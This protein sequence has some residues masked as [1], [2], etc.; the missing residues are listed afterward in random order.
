MK[1]KI[2]GIHLKDRS[3]EARIV[4]EILS[5]YGC[6]I[7]TRL[8][9]HEAGTICSPSGTILLELTGDEEEWNNFENKLI[10]IDGVEVKSMQFN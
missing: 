1:T 5:E 9:I 10:K 6:L 2:L 3:E 8:G 4:Q 7:K